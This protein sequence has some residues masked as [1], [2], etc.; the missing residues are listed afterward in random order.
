MIVTLTF[1]ELSNIETNNRPTITEDYVISE[2]PVL[3][4]VGEK[5]AL[6]TDEYTCLSPF[7]EGFVILRKNMKMTEN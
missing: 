1:Q 5:A 3:L 7:L 2:T 4:P 6:A